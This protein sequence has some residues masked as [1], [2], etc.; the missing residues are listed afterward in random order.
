MA[1]RRRGPWQARAEP[2]SLRRQGAEAQRGA[3][4]RAAARRGALTRV[5]ILFLYRW[6]HRSR[7]ERRERWLFRGLRGGADE[8][9]RLELTDSDGTQRAALLGDD[10][11][12]RR[13]L[14]GRSG[15]AERGQHVVEPAHR[16][17]PPFPPNWSAPKKTFGSSLRSLSQWARSGCRPGHHGFGVSHASY[18]VDFM[19]PNGSTE[20]WVASLT[21]SGA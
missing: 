3:I 15:A 16:A 14:R 18:Y 2:G 21:C 6:P 20:V 4:G 8:E 1:I 9:R 5:G 12:E 7:R 17:A 11:L 19:C 13:L 10:R